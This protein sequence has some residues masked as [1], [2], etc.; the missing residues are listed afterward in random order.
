MAYEAHLLPSRVVQRYV[1]VRRR[2]VDAPDGRYA[3]DNRLH[4]YRC[5]VM[6]HARRGLYLHKDVEEAVSR[7]VHSWR[8]LGDSTQRRRGRRDVYLHRP[9]HTRIAAQVKLG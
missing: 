1:R 5:D 7:E 8:L 3:V 6:Q 4:V 2:D 9:Q